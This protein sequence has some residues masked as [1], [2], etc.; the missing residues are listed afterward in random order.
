[1]P[2]PLDALTQVYAD[3]PATEPLWYRGGRRSA[4][5]AHERAAGWGTYDG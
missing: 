1:M 5:E 2:E 3:P 4:V